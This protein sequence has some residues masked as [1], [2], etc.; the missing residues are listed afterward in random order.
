MPP[1]ALQ[2]CAVHAQGRICDLQGHFC[3]WCRAQGLQ[4]AL[5]TRTS[6][7][8]HARQGGC[9]HL[10]AVW[11][12][13]GRSPSGK[14]SASLKQLPHGPLAGQSHSQVQTRQVHNS[15]RWSRAFLI[16]TTRWGNPDVHPPQ[17]VSVLK[18]DPCQS[19]DNPEASG[20]VEEASAESTMGLPS[21][22]SP[23]RGSAQNVS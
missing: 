21:H 3:L 6:K 7:L 2:P 19:T 13:D 16:T 17:T 8:L 12:A 10:S 20:S 18:S 14:Q 15:A 22:A 5:E 9:S 11:L 1:P 23:G 4:Y